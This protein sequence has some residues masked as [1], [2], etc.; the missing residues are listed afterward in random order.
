GRICGRTR[1]SR[2][3]HLGLRRAGLPARHRRA[4]PARAR[5]A[6]RPPV[7]GISS[8]S[9]WYYAANNQSVGPVRADDIRGLLSTG[10]LSPDTLVWKASFGGNWRPLR[11]PEL[12]GPAH[13][14]PVGGYGAPGSY[15]Q[16]GGYAPAPGTP[17]GTPPGGATPYGYPAQGYGP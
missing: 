4:E 10:R 5:S 8:V 17:Y 6:R 1:Q 12:M 13:P 9:D 2:R 11:A 16:P 3:R 14:P 15:P 7:A